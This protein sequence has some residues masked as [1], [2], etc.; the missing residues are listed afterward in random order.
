MLT[1]VNYVGEDGKITECKHWC[2]AVGYG[3]L[4]ADCWCLI[5]KALL[6]GSRAGPNGDP[7]QESDVQKALRR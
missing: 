4:A 3:R 6:Y 5:E 1:L 2:V 7:P